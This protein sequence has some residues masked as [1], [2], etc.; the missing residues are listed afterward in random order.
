M[1][2]SWAASVAYQIIE[3]HNN[4]EL[5]RQALPT[6]TFIAFG[7]WLSRI[8]YEE[9]DDRMFHEVRLS[10]SYY[11]TEILTKLIKHW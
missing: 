7:T 5:L 2:E 4:D 11:N 10:K 6:D 3:N 1:G 8:S 9:T